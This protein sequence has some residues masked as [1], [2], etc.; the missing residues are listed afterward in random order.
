MLMP[1]YTTISKVAYCPHLQMD[2]TL[3]GKYQIL[4]DTNKI[5]LFSVSCSVVENSHQPVWEQNETL[6]YIKCP[7][8]GR[9]ELFQNFNDG[10]NPKK[11][12]LSF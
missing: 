6:K 2:V 10:I 1:C 8:N 9:C 5:K 12:G 4:G 7:E 3:T 11:Y